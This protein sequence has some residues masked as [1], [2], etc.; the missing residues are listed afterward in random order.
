MKPPSVVMRSN[1]DTV[2]ALGIWIIVS[3]S[4]LFVSSV[5]VA[6]DGEVFPLYETRSG[7]LLVEVKCPNKTN[8]MLVATYLRRD[9]LARRVEARF[10]NGLPTKIEV[11]SS[12]HES[13]FE[14][15]FPEGNNFPEEKRRNLL[16]NVTDVVLRLYQECSNSSAL[17]RKTVD[18]IERNGMRSALIN[19]KSPFDMILYF[20]RFV[21]YSLKK[22]IAPAP[23]RIT[24]LS[25]PSGFSRSR[26]RT[27]SCW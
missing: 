22:P 3:F 13:P 11:F 7:L 25:V 24:S 27:V 19:I 1:R 14:I 10:I 16:K 23:H 12:L 17:S 6:A 2:I 4:A 9:S 15:I 8:N 18:A 5:K 26:E 21:V 20:L